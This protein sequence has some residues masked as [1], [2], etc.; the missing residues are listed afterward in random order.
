MNKIFKYNTVLLI[1]LLVC[2]CN[3]DFLK[4]ETDFYAKVATIF[5]SPKMDAKDYEIYCPYAGDATFTISNYPSWLIISPLSGQFNGSFTILNCK[6]NT[7]SLFSES[8]IYNTYF[9]MSVEGKGNA[10]VRVAYVST[11]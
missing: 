9:V 1:F 6:A 2:S 8:G 7:Y 11:H 3:D 10:L 5:I 4:E